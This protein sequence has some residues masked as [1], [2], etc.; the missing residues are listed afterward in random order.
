MSIF[1]LF[2]LPLSLVYGLIIKLRN[3]FYNKG[4][5]KSKS[6][7]LPIIAVGNLEVGGAGKTPMIEYLIR[8]MGTSKKVATISRGYG[9][10][11]KG[12]IIADQN[13]SAAE[14][15]DEPMQFNR[16]F[17]QVT[18]VASE[19]RVK[20]IHQLEQEHQVILLDDA[21]Q[22]RKV[23]AGLTI[24][25]LDYNRVGERSFLLPAGN[26]RES[27]SEMKRADLVVV[28]KAPK[29]FSPL[30]QR[31]VEAHI[32]PYFDKDIYYSY[33]NYGELVL[34]NKQDSFTELTLG[35][36]TRKTEIILLTG[37]AKT[38]PLIDFLEL[39]TKKIT[40]L[41]YADHYKFGLKDIEKLAA[42]YNSSLSTQKVII[43]TEK[44][45]MR[46]MD[47]QLA[48]EVSKLPIH[49]IPIKAEICDRFKEEFDKKIL[50]Y[51]G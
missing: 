10:K 2:L 16:K 20:A 12:L 19:N 4:V 11:T 18:V 40:H 27:K 34:L 23:K 44:D 7:D 31:I 49:Y 47:A 45:A 29:I 41:N 51:V 30:D 39:R 36:I 6:F 14:I 33:I 37:I 8:L 43:T 13:S 22:H 42:T 1:R 35:D 50:N 25:L 15:G 26:M 46:L 17:P 48:E 5:F 21:F 3:F 9:R 28:T 24:L 38:Q 32:K